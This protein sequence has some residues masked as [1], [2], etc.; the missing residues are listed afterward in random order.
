[1]LP[2]TPKH[3]LVHEHPALA[4]CPQGMWPWPLSSQWAGGSSGCGQGV[5]STQR[6][7]QVS[8]G[9]PECTLSTQ[10]GSRGCSRT[11]KP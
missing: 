7:P 6:N 3:P 1:M 8:T 11:P 4:L 9:T 2:K 10:W 5:P